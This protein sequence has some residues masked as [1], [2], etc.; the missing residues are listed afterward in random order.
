[1]KKWL[2]L[3]LAA[4]LVAGP[5]LAVPAAQGEWT[6]FVT[7]TH[8]GKNGASKD[9]TADCV[10]KCVRGGARAQ[11]LNEADQKLYELDGF[12]KVRPLMGGRVTVKGSLDSGGKKIVVETAARAGR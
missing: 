6:G 5:G 9:H 1:M 10:E 7:D 3:G 8:C 2:A 4:G 12:E 11:L